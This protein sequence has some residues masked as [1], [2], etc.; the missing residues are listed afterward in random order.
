MEVLNE[1]KNF[2][3]KHYLYDSR[4]LKRAESTLF[5]AIRAEQNDGHKYIKELYDQGVKGFVISDK[6]FD[7]FP[8]QNAY[9]FLVDNVI[10]CLQ[11]IASFHRRQ[12]KMPVLG[13]TGSN[14][15]TI[16]KEWISLLLSKNKHVVKTPHSFNSQIGVPISVLH[17]DDGYDYGVFEAG[18]S[19]SGEMKNLARIINPDIGILTNIGAAHDKGFE[20]RNNKILEK[21]K[22][23]K[24][25][26]KIIFCASNPNVAQ[27]LKKT[28]PEKKL[29]S[30]GI[31]GDWSFILKLTPSKGGS[32][33]ELNKG[34]RT[35]SFQSSFRD[36]PSIENLVH[37]IVFLLEEEFSEKSIQE[38]ISLL[39]NV[40]ARLEIKQGINN[41]L[42]IDDTYSFDP[43]SFDA[44]LNTLKLQGEKSDKLLILSD[45][46]DSFS[47]NEEAY[48]LI[49]GQIADTRF[50]ELH[51][52]GTEIRKY[53]HELKEKVSYYSDPE[54]FLSKANFYQ[55][56]DK[57][58]LIKGARQFELEKIST[59]LQK[60]IAGTILEVDLNALVHNYKFYRARLRPKTKVMVMVK[61]FAYGSGALEVSKLLQYHNVDYL[62]VAYADEGIYLRQHGIEVPIMVMNPSL[63]SFSQLIQYN[64]E[65]EIYSVDTFVTLVQAV[66]SR[67]VLPS[68]HIKLDTGMHRLGFQKENLSTLCNLLK[69]HQV[70][71]KSVFTHLV[72]TDES[73]HDD[74]TNGQISLF[75]E[76]S[77]EIEKALGYSFLKHVL[78]SAGIVRFPEYQMDLVRLGIGLYG[79]ESANLYN[80]NLKVVSTLKSIVSQVRK[81]KKGE[82]V[83]YSRKCILERDSEI[84][85]IPIGY[86]DGFSRKFG[87]G[88]G[89]VIVKGHRSP[90]VGNV[91]MDMIMID[92]TGLNV[93]A[94]DE[95]EIFGE[96]LPVK[97]Q[98]DAIDTIAY[99]ILANV[100][101]RI[102]KA[103]IYK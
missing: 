65:P 60:K 57:A 11:D 76:M 5:F 44:A 61:A 52:I 14:G 39:G 28:Y 98:A 84:A 9:F 99:E 90:V 15:K 45:L 96:S 33:I 21:I 89:K 23:F 46:P 29:I 86:A 13:I 77:L 54:D 38:G 80:G 47:G 97:E 7:V 34:D 18:I 73:A 12:F 93:E 85:T 1:G 94:G 88:L 26:E 31:E 36:K 27:I 48:K 56:F 75:N 103:Y 91:C 70:K 8:F 78:N 101:D 79:V 72:G 19:G 25:C 62:A 66:K 63:D 102:N 64:L 6:D 95:I 100:G 50:D 4:Q 43:V 41:S 55:W 81:V 2:I 40:P 68:V 51:F 67:E 10:G 58:I 82:S 30:W 53:S 92:V 20:S 32:L 37:T 71:V 59:R 17:M 35:Y 74:F 3:I 87:N 16:V 22:L 49:I 83:G 69:K 42:L 24:S